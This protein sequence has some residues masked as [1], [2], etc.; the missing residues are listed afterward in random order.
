MFLAGSVCFLVPLAAEESRFRH[1]VS[2]GIIWFS[3]SYTADNYM[4][5]QESCSATE[6]YE[7]ENWLTTWTYT[8]FFRPVT[9][10]AGIPSALQRFY[11]RSSQVSVSFLFEPTTA[12]NTTFR[13][14]ELNFLRS[15]S[16]DE[17]S[18][19]A[20]LDVEYFLT[21]NTGLSLHLAAVENDERV[22]TY[23]TVGSL[24][25]QETGKM[26][27]IRRYYGLGISHYFSKNMRATLSYNMFDVEYYRRIKGWSEDRPILF[28]EYFWDGEETGGKSVSLSG[29]YIFRNMFGI[30]AK[31]EF[32]DRQIHTEYWSVYSDNFVDLDSYYDDDVSEHLWETFMSFYITDQTTLQFGASYSTQTIKQTYEKEQVYDY[33]GTSV[34]LKT[35]LLHYLNRRIGIHV[36]YRLQ[37]QTQN[38]LHWYPEN[39]EGTR[40]TY[41]V[42]GDFHAIS[43]GIIG[44]F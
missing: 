38:V 3:D 30:Q 11:A 8:F 4:T 21:E 12:T 36:G 27:D 37:K 31:Y 32:R 10:Q 19:G 35:G 14:P 6:M 33:D 16:Q 1:E 7:K 24:T 9:E 23:K 17:K 2:G 5:D 13:N 43:L 39:E 25:Y 42:A 18:Y 22:Q 29:E 34:A 20:D 26:E 44:R 41:E 15:T 28:T 40:T